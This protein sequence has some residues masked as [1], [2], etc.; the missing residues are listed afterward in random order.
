MQ[1]INY[2]I[3][4]LV[5]EIVLHNRLRNFS[6]CGYGALTHL[7]DRFTR[8]KALAKLYPLDAL[9]PIYAVQ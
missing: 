8:V 3:T 4:Y 2:K 1:V 9:M 5:I 7:D 6:L